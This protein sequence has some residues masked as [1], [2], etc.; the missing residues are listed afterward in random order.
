M[1]ILIKLLFILLFCGNSGYCISGKDTLR[2]GNACKIQTA[3]ILSEVEKKQIEYYNNL[4]GE[5]VEFSSIY[6][7]DSILVLC[8]NN[9]QFLIVDRADSIKLLH[10]QGKDHNYYIL[11]DSS[12]IFILFVTPP[13]AASGLMPIFYFMKQANQLYNSMP[14]L[15]DESY[16]L[17]NRLDLNPLSLKEFKSLLKK[18]K[19]LKIYEFEKCDDFMFMSKIMDNALKKLVE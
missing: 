18:I 8:D 14:V 2:I 15:N 4:Y 16:L 1:K 12:K 13:L 11:D 6:L 10:Y 17:L 19:E 9:D 7:I 3:K 5:L